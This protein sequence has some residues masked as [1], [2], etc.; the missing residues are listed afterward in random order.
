MDPDTHATVARYLSNVPN[1]EPL[2]SLQSRECTRCTCK[3][4]RWLHVS[5]MHNSAMGESVVAQQ[6]QIVGRGVGLREARLAIES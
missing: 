3:N 2:A 6:L 1:Y 4:G 5:A